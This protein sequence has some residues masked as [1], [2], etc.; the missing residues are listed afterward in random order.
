MAFN[1]TWQIY[2][3]ENLEDFLRSIGLAEDVIN[4]A[5][6]VKPVIEIHQ[7][8]NNFVV[9]SKTPHQSN[10]NSFTIGKEADITAMGGKK[11]KCTINMDGGKL[12]CQ[13]DK[14]SHIS[15]IQGNEMIEKITIGSTT[16]VRKSRKV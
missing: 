10:T 4:K 2:Q 15:E 8:G 5:K 16:L 12:V 9:T 14:F 1:G 3:Q 6:D 13:T 7:D 11:F